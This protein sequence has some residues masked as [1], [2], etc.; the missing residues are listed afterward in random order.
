MSNTFSVTTL[1]TKSLRSDFK[2]YQL[3]SFLEINRPDICLLQETNVIDT[4]RQTNNNYN[5]LFNPAIN[6]YSG[7]AIAVRKNSK[8]EILKHEMICNGYLQS[9]VLKNGPQKWHVFN[10]Y[11]P[12]NINRSMEVLA[13]LENNLKSVNPRPDL[14]HLIV[15]GDFNCTLDPNLDRQGSAERYPQKSAHLQNLLGNFDM[16]DCWRV[17]YKNKGGFTF[18]TQGTPRSASRLDR[19]Y[20]SGNT[21]RHLSSVYTKL[22]FSDHLAVVVLFRNVINKQ[23]SLLY[24]RF[25][26]CLLDD[27]QYKEMMNNFLVHRLASKP[28]SG[29]ILQWW[30]NLKTDIRYMTI[31]FTRQIRRT[32]I[33]ELQA[34]EDKLKHMSKIYTSTRD[35]MSNVGQAMQYAQDWYRQRSEKV[36]QKEKLEQLVHSDRPCVNRK[37][38]SQ[39]KVL[40]RIESNGTIIESPLQLGA[41][42]HSHFTE[43]YAENLDDI[44]KNS[45]LYQDLKKLSNDNQYL[46]DQP[47]SEEEL[48]EALKSLNR[49]SSPGIDGLT[50]NFYLEFWNCI[51][52]TFLQVIRESLRRGLLPKSATKAVLSLLPKK[53]DLLKLE[54]WRA[55]SI[56]TTDYKILAKT[57]SL[58]LSTVIGSVIHP[59]QGYSIPERSIYDYLHLHRDVVA[60]ANH[61]NHPLA[62]VNLDQKAAFDNV[63]HKYLFHVLEE[64]NFGP[65]FLNAVNTLYTDAVCQ[66]KVGTLLTS[67]VMIRKGIRQGCPLSGGLYSISTEPF[68]SSCRR[69]MEGTGFPLVRNFHLTVSAYADDFSF[70]ISKDSDF[71]VLQR[72]YNVF[73]KQSGSILNVNKSV[74][75]WTGTWSHRW[76][77]PLNFRWS[78]KEIKIL[79]I[80]FSHN[81]VTDTENSCQKLTQNLETSI[82]AWKRRLPAVSLIG[83]K[84]IINRC[85]AP[86]LWHQLQILP[87]TSQQLDRLQSILINYL[88]RGK[89]WTSV[90]DVCLAINQGGLGVVHLISKANSFRVHTIHKLINPP[91]NQKWKTL[92]T[93]LLSISNAQGFTWQCF[94]INSGEINTRMTFPFTAS[95]IETMQKDSYISLQNFPSRR[96]DVDEIPTVASR[97]LSPII[98]PL[99]IYR[100]LLNG[101]YTI[102]DFKNRGNWL[103]E[104]ALM[105]KLQA[106]PPR[107]QSDLMVHF[108]R[109]KATCTLKY[110]NLPATDNN[111]S[112]K[113]HFLTADGSTHPVAKTSRKILQN[114]MTGRFFDGRSTS[115]D[116][117]VDVNWSSY[118]NHLTFGNDTEVAWRFAKNRLADC[119]YLHRIGLRDSIIC[120]FCSIATGNSRHIIL[121]CNRAQL[122]WQL[123]TPLLRKLTGYEV[124]TPD[125]IVSGFANGTP[126]HNLAN[127]ILTLAKSTVYYVVLDVLKHEKPCVPYDTVFKNRLK[128]RLLKEFAW[129]LGKN[130]MEGFKLQ[131]CVGNAICEVRNKDLLFLL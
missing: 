1:N 5:F 23:Q 80:T 47:L 28:S 122:L 86:K 40:E 111:E 91:S 46:L 100:W 52:S 96:S 42:V 68:L 44:D 127:Y 39:H 113:L 36:L 19:L 25:N 53:G 97:L 51:K 125:K 4:S 55:I 31:L 45:V 30:D 17:S 117:G 6:D 123:V 21:I 10:I 121:D 65:F 12:H 14:T 50:T 104:E 78:N 13:S 22:S 15:G 115:Y 33:S 20:C 59:D 108:R 119:V 56:L 75:F 87:F 114:T 70:Y 63:S 126:E 105:R 107:V 32:S 9:I 49:R 27:Q 129:Y 83:R 29:D 57:L 37:V 7:T 64:L 34:I 94:F 99:F 54:N 93:H 61:V 69:L 103:P 118:F 48:F 38:F 41:L 3:E 84:L 71:P 131:W 116:N 66:I 24:W 82:R 73:S 76:D 106:E 35:Q 92:S 109:I 120:P 43:K 102:A 18:V 16:L 60:Y 67:E 58:R 2:W 124:V 74:G 130:N 79:G 62:V 85:L 72:V 8:L 101:F 98:P 112:K 26:D 128:G 110:R 81:V 77:H 11:L 88:W 95:I 89:H 90:G